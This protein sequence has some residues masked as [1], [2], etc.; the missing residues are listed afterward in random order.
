MTM[1]YP[2]FSLVLIVCAL[3]CKSATV[4]SEVLESTSPASQTHT[5]SYPSS[6]PESVTSDYSAV[7]KTT[8]DPHLTTGINDIEC[9]NTDGCANP[10][11]PTNFPSVHSKITWQPITDKRTSSVATSANND[12]LPFTYL[13]DSSS[14]PNYDDENE[15]DSEVKETKDD[16][17][18]TMPTGS[19]AELTSPS[20]LESKNVL[21]SD[22]DSYASRMSEPV[23][24]HSETTRFDFDSTMVNL[25]N[26]SEYQTE[27]I[28]NTSTAIPED[29]VQETASRMISNN[30]T[31]PVESTGT[32][33]TENLPKASESQ[34][35]NLP[36][37]TS[38]MS[39]HSTEKSVSEVTQDLTTELVS[40][41]LDNTASYSTLV[42]TRGSLPVSSD[43]TQTENIPNTSTALPEQGIQ[44]SV[45]GVT[46]DQ[47]SELVSS[48]QS[49]TENIP[50][51]DTSEHNNKEYVS[52]MAENY[53]LDSASLKQDDSITSVTTLDALSSS[54]VFSDQSQTDYIP[55]TS[56]DVP[57]TSQVTQNSHILLTFVSLLSDSTLAPLS[58]SSD[59][60]DQTQTD[61]IPNA[62]SDM[63]EHIT[64][65]TLQMTLVNNSE[66]VPLKLEDSTS[67]SSTPATDQSSVIPTTERNINTFQEVSMVVTT[68]TPIILPIEDTVVETDM[69]SDAPKNIS[70]VSIS[71]FET[72][73]SGATVTTAEELIPPTSQQSTDSTLPEAGVYRVPKLINSTEELESE[74]T[75]L[76]HVKTNEPAVD[77]NATSTTPI[78]PL[79]SNESQL[80]MYT[81]NMSHKD[82]LEGQGLKRNLSYFIPSTDNPISITDYQSNP[83]Q[84]IITTTLL[85]ALTSVANDTELTTITPEK[86]TLVNELDIITKEKDHSNSTIENDSKII[87]LTTSVTVTE[88]LASNITLSLDLS[89][90][91]NGINADHRNI[92]ATSL[93]SLAPND[94]E[95]EEVT[96][97]SSNPTTEDPIHK[98]DTAETRISILDT[99]NDKS[100]S[101]ATETPYTEDSTLTPIINSKLP[102]EFGVEVSGRSSYRASTK[103]S[104]VPFTTE[105]ITETSTADYSRKYID[106]TVIEQTDPAPVNSQSGTELPS[107]V[108]ATTFKDFNNE[109]ISPRAITEPNSTISVELFNSKESSSVE[110]VEGHEISTGSTSAPQDDTS[111]SPTLY[112]I[113]TLVPDTPV[114]TSSAVIE[115]TATQHESNRSSPSQS[116]SIPVI[117]DFSLHESASETVIPISDTTVTTV[118][119]TM[120]E[121]KISSNTTPDTTPS[122]TTITTLGTTN[123]NLTITTTPKASMTITD[124]SH[125][126]TATDY[127][128]IL[129][130]SPIEKETVEPETSN[131]D[132]TTAASKPFY[133]TLP[134]TQNETRRGGK[135]IPFS[136][137]STKKETPG[138][139]DNWVI[140]ITSTDIP[141]EDKS[142]VFYNQMQLEELSLTEQANIITATI[143]L[144][145]A[146][147]KANEQ[148]ETMLK[149]HNW[150]LHVLMKEFQ[151]WTRDPF[152]ESEDNV[153]PAPF[154]NISIFY[155]S[156]TPE[157]NSSGITLTFIVYNIHRNETLQVDFVLGILN[158]YSKEL[159]ESINATAAYFYH[160]SLPGEGYL[161]LAVLEKYGVIIATICLAVILIVV[162]ICVVVT[163]RKKTR[164]S[165]HCLSNTKFKQ[166]MQE[167]VGIDLN[168]AIIILQDEKNE[169]S[170][171]GNKICDD[172]GWL[173]PI[174]DVPQAEDTNV[175][176]I[177]DTKL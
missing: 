83:T 34:T 72:V 30:E 21:S 152:E 162:L 46:Q 68:A 23:M 164:R 52:R 98:K 106:L 41:K 149:V 169:K 5:N 175:P 167:S 172:E 97:H 49:L 94:I 126:T 114:S 104:D 66:L 29:I 139:S 91:E 57:E 132:T 74:T 55:N 135:H 38:A 48:D 101:T 160:G 115:T 129:T 26:T 95:R 6:E 86:V 43:H 171:N 166:N 62:S 125:I 163:Y 99:L 96:Y 53:T 76:P 73:L 84:D 14:N 102:S 168:P 87:E 35:K 155:I 9:S 11:N 145:S 173:A 16:G 119:T 60:S 151:N 147:L 174:N 13:Q 150:L 79:M 71:S 80:Q 77:I 61:N 24:V 31:V 90:T 105:Q 20:L 85:D 42:S 120:S 56:T 19:L 88:Q 127:G 93:S 170:G 44:E 108:I 51:T 130:T 122:S 59:L 134:P 54:Q 142:K 112:S 124:A 137:L 37:T 107:S 15:L 111:S 118:A 67:S 153:N 1:S 138:S 63:P 144:P 146:H 7:P 27:N 157:M 25:W 82:I 109:T 154:G 3:V 92:E 117:P 18:G 8:G 131:A 50:N 123:Q 89:H 78:E 65:D 75:L 121:D 165:V 64:T 158:Y 156:P 69:L 148:Q 100:I 81:V 113:S 10:L 33:Q 177:Q 70:H 32:F 47:T 136:T 58:S 39:E 22:N 2:L 4:S 161:M 141:A 110:Y 159:N 45:S 128:S 116:T 140:R 28:P 12:S 17:K 143:L 103:Q 36:K 40:M 176:F 133:S